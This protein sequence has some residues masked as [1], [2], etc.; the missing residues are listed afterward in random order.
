MCYACAATLPLSFTFRRNPSAPY[1]VPDERFV[2]VDRSINDILSMVEE[3]RQQTVWP[4]HQVRERM[5][6]T[7]DSEIGDSVGA[8]LIHWPFLVG[9]LIN[10]SHITHNLS[11]LSRIARYCLVCYLCGFNRA[12]F[13]PRNN[14]MHG[15]RC[16][17]KCSNDLTDQPVGVERQ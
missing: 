16:K 2:S 14:K 3:Q 8:L 6:K 13:E 9:S 5:R 10:N 17:V 11:R 7:N 15:R 4:G 1:S 12:R